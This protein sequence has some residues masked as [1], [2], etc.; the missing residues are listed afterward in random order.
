MSDEQQLE[1]NVYHSST[2]SQPR[3]PPLR[4]TGGQARDG[5]EL[6]AENVDRKILLGRP[7]S[8]VTTSSGSPFLGLGM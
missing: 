1:V 6:H 5:R 3:Q 7:Y 4:R 2:R 8:A